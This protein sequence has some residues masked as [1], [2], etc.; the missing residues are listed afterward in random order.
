[1]VFPLVGDVFANGFHI[2]FG[3]GEDTVSRLPCEDP[4][5]WSLFPDPFGCGFFDILHC[6]ANES[7]AGKFEKKV[8]VIFDGID[9]NRMAGMKARIFSSV[10]QQALRHTA[11]VALPIQ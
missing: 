11:V 10:R 5:F 1:V 7:G 8:D 3:N 6:L 4:E 2:G 9:E